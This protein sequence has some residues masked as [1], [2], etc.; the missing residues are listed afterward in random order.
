MGPLSDDHL[1]IAHAFYNSQ[2][3]LTGPY[4]SYSYANKRATI[5]IWLVIFCCCTTGAVDIKVME[6]YST[7]SFILAFIRFSCKV[8]YPKIFLMPRVGC[9]S[10][11]LCMKSVQ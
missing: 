3:D 2:V 5:K 9:M 6:D 11:G 8:G 7:S 10:L 4:S 1:C